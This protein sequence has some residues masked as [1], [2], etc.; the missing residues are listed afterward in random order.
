MD[1]RK[2]FGPCV[3]ALEARERGALDV[4]HPGAVDDD[5]DMD[6]QAAGVEPH[7]V[8][9]P[10]LGRRYLDERARL[11]IKPGHHRAAAGEG[12]RS[13]A[14]ITLLGVLGAGPAR[15]AF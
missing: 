10:R 12:A 9:R 5:A 2:T 7:H 8:E 13:S 3:P 1:P 14:V 11:G 4:Q 15:P 6:G